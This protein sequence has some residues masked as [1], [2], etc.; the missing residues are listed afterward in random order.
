[1]KIFNKFNKIMF[2]LF[3]VSIILTIFVLGLLP[4]SQ[5][6][7]IVTETSREEWHVLVETIPVSR[8]I[9]LSVLIPTWGFIGVYFVYERVIKWLRGIIIRSRKSKIPKLELDADIF[10]ISHPDCPHEHIHQIDG[11]EL[12]MCE[13]CEAV[14]LINVIPEIMETP[15]NMTRVLVE[16]LEGTIDFAFY[17]DG[18]YDIGGVWLTPDKIKN[19]VCIS[20]VREHFFKN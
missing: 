9:V 19:W 14:F 4:I 15:N 17:K 7:T 1:M 10:N 20:E 6:I 16:L 2:S 5:M 11:S 3:I 8:F 18:M 12:V 13:Q